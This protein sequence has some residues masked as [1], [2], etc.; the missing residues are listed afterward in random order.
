MQ[1]HLENRKSMLS[2]G[3]AALVST[4]WKQNHSKTL[5]IEDETII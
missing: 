4:K 5:Q 3:K 2:K 1:G